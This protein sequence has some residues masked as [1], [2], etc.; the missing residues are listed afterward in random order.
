MGPE[1]LGKGSFDATDGNATQHLYDVTASEWTAFCPLPSSAIIDHQLFDTIM[2]ISVE[3]NRNLSS[4]GVEKRQIKP[5]G[6]ALV[7]RDTTKS[8]TQAVLSSKSLSEV[9]APAWVSKMNEQNDENSKNRRFSDM[10]GALKSLSME[11]EDDFS[12]SNNQSCR[13]SVGNKRRG[14]RPRTFR[15][16]QLSNQSSITTPVKR[17]LRNL[18]FKPTQASSPQPRTFVPDVS[19]PDSTPTET[20]PRGLIRVA[21][22]AQRAW[23]SLGEE[24][25]AMDKLE[26]SKDHYAIQRDV[27]LARRR[28]SL[29][30]D[31][32][33]PL[34]D[35][36]AFGWDMISAASSPRSPERI[37][38][39]SGT[40]KLD[41]WKS[42]L[43]A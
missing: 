41:H 21:Q 24:A 13:M 26:K 39:K 2:M 23:R 35:T 18:P 33:G 17:V 28:S 34:S 25:A 3:N 8:S 42:A 10:N 14:D 1:R 15:P 31:D 38:G 36:T 11:E 19:S 30:D 22:A 32:V 9:N 27:K 16:L 6:S 20:S 4:K 43:L 29:D 40:V 12:S 5:R 37:V 7:A